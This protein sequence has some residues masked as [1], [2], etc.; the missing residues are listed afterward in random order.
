MLIKPLTFCTLFAFI[1]APVS[2]FG[3]DT[4]LYVKE[5][6][7]R[8]G[9]RP[10][11]LVIFDNSG[12][13]STEEITQVVDYDPS[14]DYPPVSGSGYSDSR[15]YYTVGGGALPTPDTNSDRRNF[16]ASINGCNQSKA[17]LDQ[18][19]RFTGY[20]R[21][22]TSSGTTGVWKELPETDGRNIT[23]VDCWEDITKVDPNNSSSYNDGF[24]ANGLT[25][26]SGKKKK[27]YPYFISS[28]PSSTWGDA[29]AAAKNTDFGVG[30]PVT[31]YSDNYLR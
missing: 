5:S 29:L 13:M 22:F 12:S 3:D 2:T 20:I 1:A 6:T 8:T 11:V 27:A 28:Y 16:S 14:Y 4:E 24:P 31:F 26:G 18:Y 25:T 7:T 15:I 17:A 30:Q 23:I 9:A 21:E 10:K 19:G